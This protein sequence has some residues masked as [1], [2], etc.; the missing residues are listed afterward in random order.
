M[1]RGLNDNALAH[2]AERKRHGWGRGFAAAGERWFGRWTHAHDGFEETG[3]FLRAGA[4]RRVG[5][6]V[7]APDRGHALLAVLGEGGA[8]GE[9]V[10]ALE[11]L[12]ALGE[13][14]AALWRRT[15]RRRM[16]QGC[17]SDGLGVIV[18]RIRWVG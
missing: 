15:E 5:G 2:A 18:V 8:E 16:R 9:V 12:F 1:K 4:V 11:H 7:E 6:V 3:A 14:I 10:V 13:L 17:L